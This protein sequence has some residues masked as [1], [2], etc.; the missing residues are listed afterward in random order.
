MKY[1]VT[2]IV[3]LLACSNPTDTVEVITYEIYYS[4]TAPDSMGT[5]VYYVIF[6][7]ETELTQNCT[8]G[9]ISW[10]IGPYTAHSGQTL[11]VSAYSECQFQMWID[12]NGEI[13]AESVVAD[14]VYVEYL[15]P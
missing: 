2:I 5:L 14:S 15:L 6:N 11:W 10:G 9:S 7:P 13:V 12:V 8:S 3:L 1:L 4:G